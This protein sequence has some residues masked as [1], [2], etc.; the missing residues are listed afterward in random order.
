MALPTSPSPEIT[1]EAPSFSL[2]HIW[3]ASFNLL[4]NSG[5]ASVMSLERI[6]RCSGPAPPSSV[7]PRV[8]GNPWT[9]LPAWPRGHTRYVQVDWREKQL[10]ADLTSVHLL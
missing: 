3:P 8:M 7:V 4:Y 6:P 10:V 5:P 9:A 1:Q 2:S